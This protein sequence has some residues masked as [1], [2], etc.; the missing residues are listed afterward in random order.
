MDII[1]IA[2]VLLIL[3]L[4]IFLSIL[5]IQVFFILRDLKKAVD[6]LDIILDDAQVV[7]EDIKK[8]IRAAANVTEAMEEGAKALKALSK[9]AKKLFFKRR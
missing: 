7:A 3:L 6:K 4:A 8:P 2:L 5:G 9:P 1:Q